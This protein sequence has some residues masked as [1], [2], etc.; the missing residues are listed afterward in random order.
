VVYALAAAGIDTVAVD[1]HGHGCDPGPAG[2][3][4]DDAARVT[5]VLDH[6]DGPAVLV[7]HS[8]GGAVITESGGH[9]AVAH[10]VYLCA[11]ALDDGE[12]CAAA[13]AEEAAAS[14]ISHAGRPD[15]SAGFRAG[16][17]GMISLDAGVAATCLYQDCDSD[18]I[19]WATARLGPQPVATLQQSPRAVAWRTTPSTYVICTEDL[20][21]HP[22]VQRIL[23]GRCTTAVE[24]PTGHSPFLSRPDL[25]VALLSGLAAG[26]RTGAGTP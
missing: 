17:D 14:G 12:S 4:H 9:P 2:D 3:L 24:W 25:V 23:A 21:I 10:L 11:L 5:E 22:G 18:T 1:L 7:G 8:Y 13:G 20:A 19:A 26:A 6:I 16:P 15:L